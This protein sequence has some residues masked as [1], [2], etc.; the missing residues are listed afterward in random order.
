M[1]S[2]FQ[3][4]LTMIQALRRGDYP[5]FVVKNG[6]S[7]QVP[8]FYYHQVDA[9]KFR[10]HLAYLKRNGYFTLTAD[11]HSYFL[12]KPK[13][14]DAKAVVLT[15]D[16]GLEDLFTVAYPLLKS[17]GF[18][19][20]AFI[21]PEWIGRSGMITWN[22]AAEMHG[23]RVIDVQSHSLSH[24]SM[25]TADEVVDF[26]RG[27]YKS[28]PPWEFPVVRRDGKDRHINLSDLGAP[29][30]PSASRLSD[31]KRYFPDQDME[32]ACTEAVSQS[33]G[34]QFFGVKDWRSTLLKIVHE[35][36]ASNR[37]GRYE[38]DDEQEDAIKRELTL[39]RRRIEERLSGKAVKHFAFPWSKIGNLSTRLLAECGYESAYGGL[40]TTDLPYAGPQPY[41][42]NRVNADFILRLPGRGQQSLMRIIFDKSKRRLVAGSTY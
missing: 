15:F 22:Q 17:Y 38:Q 31:S 8:V 11:E 33:G 19:A 20:V 7:G 39:S 18:K 40:P 5:Q 42:I 29:I 16:D 30:F 27:E 9:D 3:D 10:A 34:K 32:R 36:R 37:S 26:V 2:L 21:I 24:M 4:L 12:R 28:S 41:R 1:N 23:S 14:L 35:Y 13:K 6:F 25:F